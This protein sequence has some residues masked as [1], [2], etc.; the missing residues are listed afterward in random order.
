MVE[1]NT[2]DSLGSGELG[3]HTQP[4][5]WLQARAGSLQ[6]SR[7]TSTFEVSI[8]RHAGKAAEGELASSSSARTDIT[9]ATARTATISAR[10]GREREPKM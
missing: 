4:L 3:T 2:V 10:E 5:S 7:R 8:S 9:V 6:G 1:E